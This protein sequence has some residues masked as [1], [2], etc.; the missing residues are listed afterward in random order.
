MPNFIDVEKALGELLADLGTVGTAV[1]ENIPDPF[2]CIERVPGGGSNSQGWQDI[3][4]VEVQTWAKTRPESMAL[5]NAIRDRLAGRR[6]V[7]TSLGLIDRIAEA[8]PP[9]QLPYADEEQRWVPSTW[10]ITSRTQ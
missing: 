1:P 6:G 4:L 7:G 8:G 2:I 3:A 10:R 5:N 9:T